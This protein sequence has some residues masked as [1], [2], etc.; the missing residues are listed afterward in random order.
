M[1][2]T[3]VTKVNTLE[4]WGITVTVKTLLLYPLRLSGAASAEQNLLTAK[5][6]QISVLSNLKSSINDRLFHMEP[7]ALS[8]TCFH[9]AVHSIAS[10]HSELS[11]WAPAADRLMLRVVC[12]LSLSLRENC[13][14]KTCFTLARLCFCFMWTNS[15]SKSVLAWKG[16]SGEAQWGDPGW[17]GSLCSCYEGIGQFS[18]TFIYK[19]ITSGH[20]ENCKIL[21]SF[22]DIS[23]IFR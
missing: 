16:E 12:A 19:S 9:V 1:L 13:A 5:L 21:I 3:F 4:T 8:Q 10:H 11:S 2:C 17:R 15:R 14:H 7:T 22:W 23:L 6:T 20:A 18:S